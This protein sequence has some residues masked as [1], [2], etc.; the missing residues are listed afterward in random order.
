MESKDT[1]PATGQQPGTLLQVIDSPCSDINPSSDGALIWFIDLALPRGRYVRYLS[2]ARPGPGFGFWRTYG[3]GEPILLSPFAIIGLEPGR[4]EVSVRTILPRNGEE[5]LYMGSVDDVASALHR[6]AKRDGFV[7][8]DRK[9]LF[10]ALTDLSNEIRR[11]QAA[12][13]A[14]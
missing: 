7:V 14:C 9:A 10:W 6:A 4:G 5:R 8:S 12:R 3:G 2:D 13:G 1:A 11:Q